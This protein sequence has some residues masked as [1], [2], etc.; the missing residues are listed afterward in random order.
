MLTLENL[1]KHVTFVDA[2]HAQKSHAFEDFPGGA[3]TT[4][5]CTNSTQHTTAYDL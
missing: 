4:Y 2:E 5:D 3:C 1:Q